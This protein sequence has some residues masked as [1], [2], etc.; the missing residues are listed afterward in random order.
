[1][2]KVFYTV[3]QQVWSIEKKLVC[4][5]QKVDVENKSLTVLTVP[6]L[7][8]E[9]PELYVSSF[10]M[11]STVRKSKEAKDGAIGF[12]RFRDT[13]IL[14][15]KSLAGDAGYDVFLDV[16][17][18]HEHVGQDGNK[19]KSWSSRDTLNI[20]MKKGDVSLLPTGIGVKTDDKYFTK[21]S[22]ERG[23]TGKLGLITLSGIVDSGY[24]GE[25]FLAISSL[26]HDTIITTEVDEATL[27]NSTDTG[28]TILLFPYSKAIAQMTVLPIPDLLQYEIPLDVF[29]KDNTERGTRKLGSTDN[30]NK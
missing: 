25:V 9:Q 4:V 16:P 28:E 20:Y 7:E 8:G 26:A 15:H 2:A 12:A 23:S 27:T 24:R 30:S 1:M 14:P 21:W 3:G 5:V 11:F 10:K 19:H 17:H 6:E 22:N 18:D 13:A 29:T